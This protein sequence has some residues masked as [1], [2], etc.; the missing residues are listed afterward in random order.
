ML[1]YL[2]DSNLYLKTVKWNQ[3][4]NGLHWDTTLERKMLQEE[5]V[6]FVDAES[7][8]DRIDAYLDYI[9][10]GIG[11]E[12]KHLYSGAS[13]EE[14]SIENEVW[15]SRY[16]YMKS[17]IEPESIG[18][19]NKIFRII[20]Y[21]ERE[22]LT[23]CYKFIL[24]ANETKLEK[25]AD[26]KIKKPANFVPPEKKIKA[27]LEYMAG[28]SYK[29]IKSYDNHLFNYLCADFERIYGAQNV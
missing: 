9:F 17:L 29:K 25:R 22:F 15:G 11:T 18:E 20:P 1:Y 16:E 4:R 24:E 28:Q 27:F 8:V 19:L 12:T 26:G 6:E 14:F 23:I 2:K 5:F 7:F 10:V 21:N 3:K 13:P